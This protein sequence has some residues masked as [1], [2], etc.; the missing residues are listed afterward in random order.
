M[1]RVLCVVQVLVDSGADVHLLSRGI[2]ETA[3]HRLYRVLYCVSFTVQVLLDSRVDVHL[4]SRG[5]EE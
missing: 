3:L 1:Y 2:G 5:I 4:L